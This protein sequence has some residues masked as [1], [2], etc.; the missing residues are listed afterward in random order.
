VQLED[1]LIDNFDY[2]LIG[3]DGIPYTPDQDDF[4]LLHSILNKWLFND[5]LS[6]VKAKCCSLSDIDFEVQGT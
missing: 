6:D 4:N 2:P 3:I 5:Q 1:D